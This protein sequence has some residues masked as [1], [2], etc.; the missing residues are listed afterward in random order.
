MAEPFAMPIECDLDGNIYLKTDNDGISSIHKLTP[1]GERAAAFMASACPDIRVQVGGFFTVGLD[2]RVYQVAFPEDEPKRYVLVFNP[3][4][5]CHSKIKLDV[6]L[7]FIPY[8]IATYPSGT[9]LITGLRSSA[10]PEV[11]AT[12]PYT[13]L[14]SSSGSL[15]KAIDLEDDAELH[16]HA[17]A[18]D[19]KYSSPT[20]PSGNTAIAR[21]VMQVARDGNVY[22]MRRVSPALIYGISEGGAVVRK[23]TVDPGESDLMPSEMHIAGNRIA[24]LFRNVRTNLTLLKVVDLEG[25]PIAE[26]AEPINNGKHILGAGFAC[27]SYPPRDTF[28]FL[29]TLEDRKLG[30][31]IVEP[32]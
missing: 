19:P 4:G 11:Q 20:N 23:I 22:L 30:F 31:R 27:Y 15:L 28:T 16:K 24:I 17:A 21:G 14:F 12:W 26:Y 29:A 9:M 3:D 6:A 8:Q 5:S 1:K 18:G 7:W 10:D 32:Q 2:N 25:K 13:A